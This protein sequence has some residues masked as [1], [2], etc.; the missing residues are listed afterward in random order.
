MTRVT[1]LGRKRTYIEAGFSHNA[2][3]EDPDRLLGNDPPA[4]NLDKEATDPPPKK[5]RKRT[6]KP[7][8][9]VEETKQSKD[10]ETGIAGGGDD[11]TQNAEKTG[12][13][14]AA[15]EKS[16]KIKSKASGKKGRDKKLKGT[17]FHAISSTVS[18]D[19]TAATWRAE[20]SELRRQKRIS[21]RQTDTICFACREK[22]HAARDCPVSRLDEL[23]D[24]AGS[25]VVQAV[26][27]C[28]RY[29]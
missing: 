6:K 21:E 28:Y 26:G 5:K 18:W 2:E 15:Q 7:K 14:H 17:C 20:Q 3:A 29:D 24:G 16:K 8:S 13:E 1:N 23:G 27:I 4:S 19:K 25:K 9:Q 11:D 10:L 12:D 22:G